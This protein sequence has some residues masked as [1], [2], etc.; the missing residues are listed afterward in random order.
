MRF[1]SR[2]FL[3]CSFFYCGSIHPG[4]PL[5]FLRISHYL[6]PMRISCSFTF[7]HLDF[8]FL[9]DRN[10]PPEIIRITSICI[11]YWKL[12]FFWWLP[13]LCWVLPLEFFQNTACEELYYISKK[14]I[15]RLLSYFYF[16]KS[17]NFSLSNPW[18]YRY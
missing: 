18:E 9:L 12:N 3:S 17:E 14:E 16:L 8:S 1:L 15:R 6:Y 4:Y 13:C 2:D 7:F 5:F 11:L 10:S